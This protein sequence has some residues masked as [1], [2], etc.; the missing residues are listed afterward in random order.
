MQE[1]AQDYADID[2]TSFVPQT[3]Q[4]VLENVF[5]DSTK[6][7]LL[8]YLIYNGRLAKDLFNKFVRTVDVG[9]LRGDSPPT[10]ANNI[11]RL[12]MRNGKVVPVVKTG[13]YA[14]IAST[15]I[16]NTLDGAVWGQI[17]QNL[18][19][20]WRGVEPTGWVWNAVL[21]GE[22]CPI[23]ANHSTGSWSLSRRRLSRRAL[24]ARC[25]LCIR[26]ADVPYF[27]YSPSRLW[28]NVAYMQT[29]TLR[30][31]LVRSRVNLARKVRLLLR[32]LRT[33]LR[34]LRKRSEASQTFS[35]F[36]TRCLFSAS[37]VGKG[38]PSRSWSGLATA[39]VFSA[40]RKRR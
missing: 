26:T 19:L 22:T 16:K 9:L 18:K 28:Q 36:Q 10:I 12:T 13:S 7:P 4:Q 11:L 39:P 1:F 38:R 3:E 35:T 29:S 24:A 15:Q 6:V 37:K 33:P 25:H 23:C 5:I 17:N 8:A 34:R 31:R 30:G 2:E 21:D 32:I 20:G 14:N 27:Q 40:T